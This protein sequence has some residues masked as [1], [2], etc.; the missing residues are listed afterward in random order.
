MGPRGTPHREPANIRRS[1][2]PSPTYVTEDGEHVIVAK[3]EDG[4]GWALYRRVI[5][6]ST[7]YRV[8]WPAAGQHRP[9]DAAIIR[10]SR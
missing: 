5:V 9:D 10:A 3:T 7:A 1:E 6:V 2:S 4:G 8:V